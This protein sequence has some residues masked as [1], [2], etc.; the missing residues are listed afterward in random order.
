[1]VESSSRT[2]PTSGEARHAA[3]DWLRATTTCGVFVFHRGAP[4]VA[5]DWRFSSESKSFALTVWSASLLVIL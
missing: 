5:G 2:D 4:Y 3:F 1:M